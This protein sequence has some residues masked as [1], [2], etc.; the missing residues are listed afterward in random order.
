LARSFLATV[1]HVAVN[2]ATLPTLLDLEDCPPVLEYTSVSSTKI[3][4]FSLFDR[5]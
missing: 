2:L 1:L 5:T 3:L 4:T